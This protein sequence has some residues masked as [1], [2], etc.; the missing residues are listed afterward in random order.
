MTATGKL[1]VWA[2]VFAAWRYLATQWRI[3]LPLAALLLLVAPASVLWPAVLSPIIRLFSTAPHFQIFLEAVLRELPFLALAA[4]ALVPLHRAIL[5]GPPQPDRRFPF[6]FGRREALYF[7]FVVAISVVYAGLE[8]A[9]LAIDSILAGF[10]SLILTVEPDGSG[11]EWLMVPGGMI[12]GIP[13]I[14][15]LLYIPSRFSLALPAIATDRGGPLSHAWTISRG[16]GWRLVAVSFIAMLPLVAVAL[17]V[18]VM[19]LYELSN[20]EIP[21]MTDSGISDLGSGEIDLSRVL[22]STAWDTLAYTALFLVEAAALS[23]SYRALGGM[24]EAPKASP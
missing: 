14:L 22:F 13:V 3:V 24:E 5:T 17:L 21:T 18:A 11:L 23:L 10:V 8:L 4:I 1:P 2:T 16:N 19:L 9:P 7:L 20:S 12:L 6:R 15:A